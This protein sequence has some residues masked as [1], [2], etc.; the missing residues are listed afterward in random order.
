MRSSN[1]LK[2]P[3][4]SQAWLRRWRRRLRLSSLMT[5]VSL[6]SGC[7]APTL[8]VATLP[9][10]TQTVAAQPTPASLTTWQTIA[11]GLEWR[12]YAPGGNYPLTQFTVLRVDTLVYTLRAHYRPGQPLNLNAWA[13]QLPNAAAFINANFFDPQ[14][15]ALGMVVSDGVIYGQSF[16][17]GGMVQVE[18][19][20]VRVRHL[21]SEPFDGEPLE[22]AVQAFPM[23]VANGTSIYSDNSPDRASRRTVAAQDADGRLVLLVTSSLIGMRLADLS[24]YLTTTDLNLVSAVNLDG[25]GSSMMAVPGAFNIFSFDAV[26]AVL[27]VYPR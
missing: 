12:I 17:R 14:F 18:N 16:R 5:A 22:Q 21:N 24:S 19:G 23:L 9:V 13:E 4:A 10:P 26:P 7:I 3:S 27:A 6:I 15:T 1:W 2:H 25:G 11:P 8:G 20:I